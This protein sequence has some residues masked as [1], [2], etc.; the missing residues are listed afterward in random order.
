MPIDASSITLPGPF[1]YSHTPT[2]STPTSE[3]M[4]A[5]P[6]NVGIKAMEIYIPS[7]VRPLPKLVMPVF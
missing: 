2:P 6:Q 4:A 5:R 3:T 7:Q 1:L